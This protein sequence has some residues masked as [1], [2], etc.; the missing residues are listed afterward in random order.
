MHTKNLYDVEWLNEDYIP[1]GKTGVFN[2]DVGT[3]KE[4]DVDNRLIYV[5]YG[6]KVIEYHKGI[7]ETLDLAY[8]ISVHKSQGSGSR[9]VIMAL[10]TSHYMNLKRSLVYTGITRA[11]ELLF[12]IADRKALSIAINNNALVYKRTFLK[13][14]II[15]HKCD[16]FTV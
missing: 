4:I 14:L 1:T 13:D 6:D 12:L 11:S 10:D 16:K 2:G 15:N 8:C 7:F 9:V 3:I 5:D